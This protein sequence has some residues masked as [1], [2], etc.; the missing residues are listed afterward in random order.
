MLHILLSYSPIPSVLLISDLLCHVLQDEVFHVPQAQQ[1]CSRN[2]SHWNPMI[3]TLP[4]LYLSSVLWVEPL[5]WLLRTTPSS[6]CHTAALRAQNVVLLVLVFFLQHWLLRKLHVPG[7]GSQRL[8]GNPQPNLDPLNS[9]LSSAISPLLSPELLLSALNLTTFPL[10]FFFGFLYYTDVGATLMVLLGYALSTQRHHWGAA[11]ALVSGVCFRQTSIVW[12]VFVAGTAGLEIIEPK[13]FTEKKSPHSHSILTYLT[14][15]LKSFFSN[16][17]SLMAELWPYAAVVSG[18]LVFVAWNGS[19]VVGDKSHHQASFHLPQVLYYTVF[20][21]FFASGQLLLNW[22]MTHGFAKTLLRPKWF[23]AAFLL[24]VLQILAVHFY[25]YTHPYLLADNRHYPFYVWKNIFKRHEAVKYLLVPGYSLATLWI[26]YA[27]R[28]TRTELWVL[29]YCVCCFVALVP[30]SLLEFRYFIIPYLL[31][32]L[33]LPQG[34]MLS[35]VA[36]F[37]T[38]TALNVITIWL[39]L[40]RPFHWPSSAAEQRFMW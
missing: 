18:F 29:L 15:A 5:S 10:L 8:F 38:H 2:F 11:T 24:L 34:T 1:Y 30:Q 19:I 32:R 12:V 9:A 26:V 40:Y 17:P 37:G 4:G 13:F 14:A 25:T 33:H 16:I 3:T 21:C 23:L 7:T 20:A 35:L 28:R 27:L 36:E 39:F 6:L 22:R 31:L